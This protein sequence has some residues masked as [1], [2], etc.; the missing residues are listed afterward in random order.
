VFRALAPGLRQVA[1]LDK[2]KLG[3][4]YK[5]ADSNNPEEFIQ[6]YHTAIDAA[7]GDDRVKA[8]YLHMAL[9]GATRC[10]LINLPE[11]TIYNWDQLCACSSVTSRAHTSVR[12]LLK[13]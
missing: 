9:T 10:W 7:E 2:F 4:I 13:F 6:V 8:N 1:W 11:G 5:Y 12:L 3:L